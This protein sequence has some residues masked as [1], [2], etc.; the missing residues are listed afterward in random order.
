MSGEH[1][2]LP[3]VELAANDI[4]TVDDILRGNI[5]YLRNNAKLTRQTLKRI[6]ELEDL[7]GRLLFLRRGGEQSAVLVTVN[8]IRCI[9]EAMRTFVKLTRQLV[10]QSQERDE[11]LGA[12]SRLR[13]YIEQQLLSR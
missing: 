11:T 13:K 6:Q 8:D 1:H 2:T 3:Q 10:P 9:H 5:G 12:V 4:K 7:R